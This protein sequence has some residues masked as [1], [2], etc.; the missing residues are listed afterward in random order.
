MQRTHGSSYCKTKSMK[1]PLISRIQSASFQRRFNRQGYELV[2]RQR[3][4]VGT[5]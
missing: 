5:C 2:D 4:D 3:I 1:K